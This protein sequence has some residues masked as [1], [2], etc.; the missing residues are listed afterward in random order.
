MSPLLARFADWIASL[1]ADEL[2]AVSSEAREHLGPLQRLAARAAH[3]M[4]EAE[5]GLYAELGIT[6]SSA[7]GR[8]QGDLTSQLTTEVTLPTGTSVSPM[9]AVRGLASSGDIA[10]RKAGYEAEMRAWPTIS[11][12]CAAAM[13]SIKGEANIVN[14]RR[15]WASPLD[16]SLYGNSVSRATFDAMQSAVRDSLPDFRAWMRVK[17]RLNGDPNGLSW[18]NMMA[19][20]A[21]RQ[22]QSRGSGN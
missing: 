1:G 8:L 18:W 20:S 11:V 12:A 2:A 16:A 5:E 14:S 17:G 3:Q 7:W 15:K 19:P 22:A 10:I 9:A 21:S 4:S 6:G 13:N